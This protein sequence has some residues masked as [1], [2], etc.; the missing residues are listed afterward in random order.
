MNDRYKEYLSRLTEKRKA[1]VKELDMY[2][3]LENGKTAVHIEGRV[4]ILNSEDV[5]DHLDATEK[6]LAERENPF[7]DEDENA[8]EDSANLPD[9]I[10][11]RQFQTPVKDQLDRGTCVCFASLA[12][13]ESVIKR[14]ENREIDLSE[15][16]A[17][18]LFMKEE[19]KNHCNDG[20]VT[21]L[22]ARYLSNNGVC[23]ESYYSYEDRDTVNTHCMDI[24]PSNVQQKATYGVGNFVLIDNLGF[25]GP[26]I[27]NPQYLE[28]LLYRNFNIV[29]GTHVAWGREPNTNDVFDV[30]LDKYG[31]P[32][33]SNGGHAMLIVGYDRSGNNGSIPYFIVKNSWSDDFGVDGYMYLSYDYITTYAKYGYIVYNI[34]QDMPTP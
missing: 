29:F 14:S 13:I 18:W 4:F 24:P 5:D 7:W 21:T 16:Y 34:R 15:Q 8:P 22:S 2:R 3:P 6:I 25:F 30:I 1:T 10:D 9:M 31:N 20:L 19:G 11:H 32:L 26:S 28:E 23:E 12:N 33:T 27:R 17:N